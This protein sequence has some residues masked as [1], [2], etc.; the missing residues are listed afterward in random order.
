MIDGRN[1]NIEEIWSNGTTLWVSDRIYENEASKT[2]PNKI[3]AFNL[4]GKT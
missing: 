1:Y 3:Y 4:S 2:F